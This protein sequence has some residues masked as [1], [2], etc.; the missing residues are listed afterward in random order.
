MKTIQRV[1]EID[2]EEVR[3]PKYYEKTELNG[4]T[5]ETCFLCGKEIKNMDKAAFVH[6]TT[7]NTII[8]YD[9][10]D[11]DVSQGFFPVGK[12]CQKKLVINFAFKP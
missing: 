9:G 6:Y 8:S 1:I 5:N 2:L 7:N 3:S 10:S 4:E 11:L 12:E